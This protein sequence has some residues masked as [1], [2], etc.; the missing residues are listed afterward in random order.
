MPWTHNLVILGRCKSPE[1]RKFYLETAARERWS[2]RELER[3]VDGGLFLHAVANPA[4]ASAVVAAIQPVVGNVFKDGY[5]LEF[6]DLPQDHSERDLRR[7]IVADLRRFLL[8]LGR[9]F[10]FVG[11]EYRLQ[12]GKK[13]F[14]VDLLFFHRGMSCLVAFELKVGEF[15]P[16]DLGQ[17]SFY[18]EALDRDHRKPHEGPAIGELLCAGKDRDVVEYAL[19]RTLSPALVADYRT[20]MPAKAFLEAKLA[21]FHRLAEERQP[22]PDAP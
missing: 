4:Q 21:E 13:D 3:Q 12:V 16:A 6:L 15:A 2:R 19:S 10:C 7:G 8:E 5:L 17:L 1:E 20:A 18:L 9:D 14:S 22:H 11:E